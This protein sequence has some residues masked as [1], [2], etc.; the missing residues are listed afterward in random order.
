MK[1]AT[2]GDLARFQALCEKRKQE[3]RNTKDIDPRDIGGSTYYVSNAGDDDNDGL[4]PETAWRTLA[5]ASNARL[6]PGDCVRFRRGDI[7]RGM[8]CC[9]SGVT[10]TGYGVGEKPR[11]YGWEKSLADP[12]LWVCMDE[13][14]HIWKF[15][16]QISDCG[17]LVFNGGEFHSRKLIPSYIRGRFMCR[18]DESRPFDMVQEMTRDLDIFCYFVGNQETRPSKGES[19]PVPNLYHGCDGDLFLRCDKGNP[20]SV[21]S[22]IEAVPWTTTISVG[23]NPC[24][25]I[26]NICMKYAKFGIT[27]GG[28]YIIGLHVTNCEIGWIGG[29]IQSYTGT[30]P[31]YPEGTRGSVTRFGNGIEIY[32]GCDDFVVSNCYVYQVYD[33]AMSHQVSTNGR[34]YVMRN[35]RYADNVIEK[36]VYGIEYFLNKNR[37]GED[38]YMDNLEMSGNI[39]YDTG[40]GWGQQRHNKHTP[41][42]IKGWSYENTASN[43]RIHNNIFGRAAYRMVHLVAREQESCP[44]MY[45]N[46]YIQNLGATLGQYGANQIAEPENLVFD[47]QAEEKIKKIFAEENPTVYYIKD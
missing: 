26:D 46:T 40:Y 32:G 16:D 28:A 33:A 1:A 6:L 34:R 20:G 44:Q 47:E 2:A 11:F 19:F 38:S 15:L 8:L 37:G 7:F 45:Q 9:K 31:N 36:C 23:G 10:Y 12:G 22:E 35:I 39:I 4:T 3:I 27:G 13:K 25:H 43:Y 30:D 42:H 24:V 21:F 18:E 29:N 14:H 17:T 5:K 41:A